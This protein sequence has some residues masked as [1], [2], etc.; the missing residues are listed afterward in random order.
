[1][2]VKIIK[3]T[4]EQ[5]S[6]VNF[7][8]DGE[9]LVRGIPGAGK[10]TVIIERA[11][12]LQKKGVQITTGPKVLLLTYNKALATY[13]TQMARSSKEEP[14]GALTFHGWGSSL[15]RESG[16]SNYRT[17]DEKPRFVKWAKNTIN[18]YGNP[19]L[20]R[21]QAA[22]LS[23]DR[24]LLRFLSEEIT[25]IKSNNIKSRSEYLEIQR[26]GRG[27]QI[28]IT[29]SHRESIYD[30]YEKYQELL[31]S[32]RCIDFD[33]VALLIIKN[34]TRIPKDKMA[35]HILIDEAQDLSPAQ[36]RAIK[37]MT[38]KSLTIAADKGQQIY[39]RHFTWK[40]VGIEI[41]GA[42][43]KLLGIT[44]RST[45]EI[46][47]LARS[48]QSHDKQLLADEDFLPSQDPEG[49]GPKPE[50]IISDNLENEKNFVL[51][52]V[53]QLKDLY[54]NDTIAIIAYSQDRLNEYENFLSQNKIGSI[55]IKSEE[56]N[57]LVPGV[58]LVTFHSSKGLEFEHVIV[59]GLQDGKIPFGIMDPGDDPEA[60]KAT[61]RKK[62]YVAMTRARLT[63][64]LLAVAPIS[65]FVNE[66][67]PDLYG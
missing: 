13:I 30:I 6:C 66:L 57:F 50:L 58:K 59:T 40:S 42:R 5:E 3:L 35:S 65:P 45:K 10:T 9:L 24:A 63:L 53:R 67:N 17:T 38:A 28:Q 1:M 15:L 51:R 46:I 39:R 61:E 37:L 41:R 25:W 16:I 48:L 44:H 29:K 52:K 22:K 32:E 34:A 54:P 7:R 60:F 12:F 19:D 55:H 20:P 33:D 64:T 21:V 8:P 49:S 31:K 27:T 4:P 14:V 56:A 23:E 36:F 2:A 11:L 43:S 26:T 47:Q 62:L 18:K